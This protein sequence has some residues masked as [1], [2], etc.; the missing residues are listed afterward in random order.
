MHYPVVI[1]HNGKEVAL[2]RMH[3]WVFSGA[4]KVLPDQI[5]EGDVVTIV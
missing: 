2:K 3:P 1:L 4:I 5:K